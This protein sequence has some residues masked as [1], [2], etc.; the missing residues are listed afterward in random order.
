LGLS[1]YD[2]GQSAGE[3]TV[4]LTQSQLP[5]HNHQAHCD[6]AVGTQ[7]GPNNGSWAASAA[8]R[9]RPDYYG[10]QKSAN[11]MASDALGINGGNQPHNNLSP[12]LAVSF[13]IAMQGIYPARN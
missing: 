10:T 13:I 7:P 6:S 9:G 2:L 8:G 5:Q 11:T 1:P 12:Y 3:P 4:T